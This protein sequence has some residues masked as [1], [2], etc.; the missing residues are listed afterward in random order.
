M[1]FQN[2]V[3]IFLFLLFLLQQ[4]HSQQSVLDKIINTFVLIK[5]VQMAKMICLK[6]K[7][8]MRKTSS[9]IT[10]RKMEF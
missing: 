2:I 9:S 5:N 3:E 7:S 8:Q 10:M 4:I 1:L 6:G